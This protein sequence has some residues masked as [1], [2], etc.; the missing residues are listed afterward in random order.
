MGRAKKEEAPRFPEFRAAFLELM[1]DMTLQE[2]ADKLGMSRATVGFY[3]AGKRIPDA[4]GVKTIAE[5]CNV[6]ADWLLGLTGDKSPKARAVDVLGIPSSALDNLLEASQSFPGIL[7]DLF[8]SGGFLGFVS[9]IYRLKS[10]V[11]ATKQ[12]HEVVHKIGLR[13]HYASVDVLKYIEKEL[14]N[15]LGYPVSLV[16]PR[17]ALYYCVD[18]VKSSAEA[19]AKSVS[20]YNDLSDAEVID[21]M[22]DFAPEEIKAFFKHVEECE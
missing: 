2:F 15:F 11:Y 17:H 1:G 4:L 3:T 18:D 8:S 13:E 22:F 16:E 14:A 9:T 10:E 6:S 19:L 7:P 21:H 12:A 20:G 5:K